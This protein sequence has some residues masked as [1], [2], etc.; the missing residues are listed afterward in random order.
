MSRILLPQ[1]WSGWPRRNPPQRRK[2]AP[3]G[4]A[5]RVTLVTP[6]YNQD[7]FLE[8]TI[9][10]V[11]NQGYPNLE[12]M[13]FDGGSTDRTREILEQY[14]SRLAYWESKP[15]R[16]Q[17]H[18][19]NKG[20]AKAT[21]DYVWWL[22][23]DDLLA[24][25]ALWIS[26]ASL[27]THPEADLAYGDL[28][29]IEEDG[30][31]LDSRPSPEF[32]LDR[33]ISEGFPV[34]QAGALMRRQVL[35][36][37]GF[38]DEDLH[39]L[40]DA[41][42]WLRL[43]LSGGRLIRVPQVVALFRVH[44]RAKTQTGSMAAIRERYTLNERLFA[45]PDLPEAVRA[46]RARSTS[47]MHLACARGYLKLGEYRMS[48]REVGRAARTWPGRLLDP[49]LWWHL[50]LGLVGVVVGERAWLR[51]R[52]LLRRARRMRPGSRRQHLE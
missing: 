51:L 48:L 12:Y 17:A 16:G 32:E 29:N 24:P 42:Y 36:R 50:F 4:T 35:D 43:A 34:A 1:E 6:S 5:R 47:R 40:M 45:R 14:G 9:L 21:G 15:D 38:L 19:I 11:L 25:E 27:E 7:R 10:S 41:D 37:I 13:V 33:S 52:G 18:A 20:W 22:N 26:V 23:A 39:Y 31:Y 49:F 44:G 2:A 30:R 46:H 28:I 3:P 8:E